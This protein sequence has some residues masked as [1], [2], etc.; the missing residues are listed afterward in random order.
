[1]LPMAESFNFEYDVFISY[2]H[3]DDRPLSREEEGWISSF[4]YSFNTR[5]GQLLGREPKIWRDNKL[6]GND[7]FSDEIIAKLPKA[8][9]LLTVISPSY[10]GSGL[11]LKE[12]HGFLDAAESNL[13]IHVSNKSRIFKIVKT[14]VPYKQHPEEI[15]GLNGYHFYELDEKNR[16]HEFSPE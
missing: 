12:L 8:K 16:P 5:L 7:E 2:T 15:R 4:H 1:M 13:G 11:C 6:Q 10:L 14:F 9:V 3:R